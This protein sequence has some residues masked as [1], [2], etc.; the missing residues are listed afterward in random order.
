MGDIKISE[1]DLPTADWN[2]LRIFL[3]AAECGSI[4]AAAKELGISQPT[5]SQRIRA[6]ELSLRTLLLVR[7]ANGISLTEA[8]REVCAHAREMRTQMVAIRRDIEQREDRRKGRVRLFAPDGIISLWLSRHLPAFYDANPEIDLSIDVGIWVGDRLREDVDLSIQFDPVE[9]DD[10][11]VTTLAH[12]HYM[13]MASHA[14]ISKHGRPATLEDVG[15]LPRIHHVAQTR[16]PETWR[17]GVV[18]IRSAPPRLETNSSPAVV[19]ATAAGAGVGLLPTY[20]MPDFPS[21]GLLADVS[22]AS[23]NLW[24]AHQSQFGEIARVRA[25]VD[26]LRAS[27]DPAKYPW[28]REEFIH[29]DAFVCG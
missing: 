11:T 1:S 17:K 29:P 10:L 20:C 23:L 24:L 3:V 16:Q 5:A 9:D 4:R 12:I 25:V 19:I 2:D 21:L 26:W 14:F 15:L 6:L 7:H 13:P 8:G 27:F 22:V 28:F 18:D